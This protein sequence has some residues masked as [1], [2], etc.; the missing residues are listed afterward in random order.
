MAHIMNEL[1]DVKVRLRAEPADEFSARVL[2]A[3]APGAFEACAPPREGGMCGCAEPD[4]GP[5][6]PS[7]ALPPYMGEK[8]AV[9]ISRIGPAWREVF[10][11]LQAERIGLAG[12]SGEVVVH[13][14][15]TPP[16]GQARD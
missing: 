5:G 3:L 11:G 16:D 7:L 14:R 8:D 13:F 10:P 15:L 6:V 1:P 9:Q 12:D 2:G 4:A